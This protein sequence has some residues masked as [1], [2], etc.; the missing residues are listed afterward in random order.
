MFQITE[1]TEAHVA[2]V[3]NR[4]ETHG[5]EKCPAVSIG[6]EITCSNTILDQIDVNL[7]PS[8]YIA[9][10]AQAQLPGIEPSTPVLRCNSIETVSLP[11]SHEGWT[12]QVDDGI[13]DTTPMT[14]GGVKVD[15]LR[16]EPHQ[17]G[18]VTLRLRCG[19]S[20]I[21]AERLGKLGMH[22]G[23]SIWITLTAPVPGADVI[24]GSVA[25]FERD[26]PDATDLFAGAGDDAGDDSDN[27]EVAAAVPTTRRS[28]A[29]HA[30]ASVVEVE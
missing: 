13:D 24:D 14:F 21:D 15:K 28:R 22:N 7:R 17:G 18:S 9:D 25:A 11:N 8:L 6:L 4:Q 20:D 1:M 5:E 27:T 16:V 19:T 26:H 23:Q 2:S 30:S 29:R 12:L 3:T 10:E